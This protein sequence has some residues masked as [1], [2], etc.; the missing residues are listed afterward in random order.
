M[1]L[2]VAL[3]CFAGFI[4]RG[5]D[6]GSKQR[7]QLW[8]SRGIWLW[9]AGRH[10]AE[11]EAGQ[12]CEDPCVWFHHTQ[13]AERLGECS[14]SRCLPFFIT[15]FHSRRSHIECSSVNK[16]FEHPHMTKPKVW[17]LIT[18]MCVLCLISVCQWWQ[19]TFWDFRL[20]NSALCWLK[21]QWHLRSWLETNSQKKHRLTSLLVDVNIISNLLFGIKLH[22]Y[23]HI[24]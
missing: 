13:K 1:N 17:F 21:H 5:A 24:T 2:N 11:A 6:F 9:A 20:W 15:A 22:L 7:L 19:L 23:W 8:S 3:L 16:C 18:L 14:G 4:P 12:E 10:P